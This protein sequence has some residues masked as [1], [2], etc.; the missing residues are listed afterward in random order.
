MLSTGSWRGVDVAVAST[1]MIYVARKLEEGPMVPTTAEGH[2]ARY[3]TDGMSAGPD[4]IVPAD[5]AARMTVAVDRVG[6]VLVH[7]HHLLRLDPSTGATIYDRTIRDAQFPDLSGY[8]DWDITGVATT[9]SNQAL[10]WIA[11]SYPGYKGRPV[12]N[13]T[14][15]RA[16][17]PAGEQTWITSLPVVPDSDLLP[18][19]PDVVT[20]ASCDGAGH[21][22]VF[23][24]NMPAMIIDL[25]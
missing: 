10:S 21:C 25:P 23:G 22:A 3:T 2:V 16:T 15:L 6:A 4:W 14:E 8:S 24:P 12:S 13:G 9:T 11:W 20:Q 18:T 19:Q 7:T 17:T 5:F 1:G